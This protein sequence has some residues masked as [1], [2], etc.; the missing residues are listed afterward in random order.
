MYSVLD[1]AKY[2]IHYCKKHGYF[3]SNLKLQKILYYVQAQFLVEL[4]RPCFYED[5]EAW[6]FG[7]VVPEAYHEYKYFGSSNIID[8][9]PEEIYVSTSERMLLDEIIEECN[10][11][12]ASQLVEFTHNQ[13]PW[14]DA[15]Q[16]YYNNRISNDAIRSYFED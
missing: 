14:K 11:Y 9:P 6:D 12:S 2:I 3:I 5:I 10:K 7:P 13:S 1:I 15:Y 4:G 16:K 8:D